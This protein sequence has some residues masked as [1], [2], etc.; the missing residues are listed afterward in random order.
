MDLFEAYAYKFH[1][2]DKIIVIS[3]DTAPVEN[4]VEIARDCDILVHEVYH[5]KGFKSRTEEWKKI[6]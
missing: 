4:M 2:P 1:T 6:S 3:G 5:F